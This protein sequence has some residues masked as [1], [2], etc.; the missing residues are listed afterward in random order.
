MKTIN[1]KPFGNLIRVTDENKLEY[2]EL[3]VNSLF[4]NGV[5]TQ[6][7]EYRE[8]LFQMIPHSILSIF[9][10]KELE[11]LI[12][13]RERINLDDL[14]QHSSFTG[15]F[16]Q[17]LIDEF[18]SIVNDFNEDEK[19]SLIKFVTGS[20]SVPLGGFYQL[21]PHFTINLTPPIQNGVNR[22]PISH[23]CFNRLDIPINCLSFKNLKLAITEGDGFS[24]V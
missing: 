4:Y 9:N 17:T 3:W 21:C 6:I 15:Y 11:M 13:G 23:T 18:W 12:C 14:K 2:L 20:S 16:N 5:K 8:G 19:K 22:L 24:L 10:W 7:E 1:L